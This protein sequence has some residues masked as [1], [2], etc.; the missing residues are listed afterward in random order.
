[1]AALRSVAAAVAVSHPVRLER[2]SA[3]RVKHTMPPPQQ[4]RDESDFDQLPHNIPIS[5]TIADIEEK[6]GFIDYFRFVMEV[7]TRGGTGTLVGYTADFGTEGR[8]LIPGRPSV[9]P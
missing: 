4:L 6:K 3:L 8:G 5:A 1:M 7:K 2:S 9:G